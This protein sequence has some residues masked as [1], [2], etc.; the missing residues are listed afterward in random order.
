MMSKPLYKDFPSASSGC[1]VFP[2]L[3]RLLG[4]SL[5]SVEDVWH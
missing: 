1:F 2:L 3:S 4:V 5:G